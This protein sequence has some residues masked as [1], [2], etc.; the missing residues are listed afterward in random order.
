MLGY[1][2]SAGKVQVG[3]KSQYG[4]STKRVKI[5]VVGECT[6]LEGFNSSRTVGVLWRKT[7]VKSLKGQS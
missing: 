4:F 2:N 6:G 7:R 5:S 1:S 3:S